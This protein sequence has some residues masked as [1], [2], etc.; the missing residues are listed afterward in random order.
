MVSDAAFE[1]IG[2]YLRRSSIQDPV[3]TFVGE[4]GPVR[5]DPE[6][7]RAILSGNTELARKLEERNASD[8]PQPARVVPDVDS[9]QR[10]PGDVL[11]EGRGIVFA[12]PTQAIPLIVGWS[13]DR[14]EHGIVM[15]DA[16]G[17]TKELFGPRSFLRGQT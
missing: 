11:I 2:E 16:T 3:V 12:F 5:A 15:K 14:G 8:E 10:Y 13:I 7:A 4:S 1:W 6:V 17:A 9:R